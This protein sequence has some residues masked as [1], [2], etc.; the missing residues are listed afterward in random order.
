MPAHPT[1]GPTAACGQAEREPLLKSIL[2]GVQKFLHLTV[3]GA[4]AISLRGKCESRNPSELG[5]I[6]YGQY[7]KDRGA[8][9]FTQCGHNGKR[10]ER[11]R[12]PC[13]HLLGTKRTS[14][15]KQRAGGTHKL[16][17]PGQDVVQPIPNLLLSWLQ[18]LPQCILV[19]CQNCG[20]SVP[21]KSSSS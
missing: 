17:G 1:S 11:T 21:R 18:S 8:R 2:P 14:G 3:P 12:D 7:T 20:T 16:T 19:W 4:A 6:T 5:F 13:V 9:I 10:G 15:I